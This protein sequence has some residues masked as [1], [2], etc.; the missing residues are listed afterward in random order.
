MEF[1]M[2]C[3]KRSQASSSESLKTP[4]LA[5]LKRR[6]DASAEICRQIAESHKESRGYGSECLVDS[7]WLCHGKGS[8]MGASGFSAEKLTIEVIG[9]IGRELLGCRQDSQLNLTGFSTSTRFPD[10]QLLG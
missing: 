2:S 9:R 4:L 5:A 6:E 3:I 10:L 1:R 7:A 8:R